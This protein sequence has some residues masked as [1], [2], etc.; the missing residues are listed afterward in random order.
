MSKVQVAW[1]TDEVSE[2]QCHLMSCSGQLKR[3]SFNMK[4]AVAPRQAALSQEKCENLSTG[5]P[6]TCYI[7][8]SHLFFDWGPKV[9]LRGIEIN[10]INWHFYH[11]LGQK[12]AHYMWTGIPF[13]E[14]QVFSVYWIFIDSLKSFVWGPSM[15]GG[16]CSPE[17]YHPAI[18]VKHDIRG[19]GLH[20]KM[21]IV[22]Q[23]RR[24]MMMVK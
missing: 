7:Q 20:K 9:L 22:I 24:R 13:L 6:A 17:L 4:C 15:G 12:T 14:I 21:S 23:A 3:L 2:W 19:V 18:L 1:V 8:R 11:S 16:V 10:S 5:D